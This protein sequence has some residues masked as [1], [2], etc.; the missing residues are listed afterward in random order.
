[1]SRKD[2]LT[3]FI[4]PGDTWFGSV[5][6]LSVECR[7]VEIATDGHTLAARISGLSAATLD[8][9]SMRAILTKQ[10]DSVP[11]GLQAYWIALGIELSK[12]DSAL[13]INASYLARVGHVQE[14]LDFDVRQRVKVR[15]RLIGE[16]YANTEWR[17]GC[18]LDPILWAVRPTAPHRIDSPSVAYFGAIMPYTLP[19]WRYRRR[20]SAPGLA[21]MGSGSELARSTYPRNAEHRYRD[22]L[23]G[24]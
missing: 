8:F 5:Y 3:R 19:S 12:P 21:P 1:M 7:T 13:G 14:S 17:F 10:P 15:D 9:D 6:T 4:L 23:P 20:R 22:R 16:T 2:P 18:A 11:D 24:C